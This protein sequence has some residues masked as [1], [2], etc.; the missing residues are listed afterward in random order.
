MIP[1]PAPT[2]EIQ[3]QGLD[4][5]KDVLSRCSH[6]GI[7]SFKKKY[8]LPKMVLHSGTMEI[9]FELQSSSFPFHFRRLRPP[10]ESVPLPVFPRCRL[11]DWREVSIPQLVPC[12]PRLANSPICL[13][14]LVFEVAPGEIGTVAGP[15][16]GPWPPILFFFFLGSPL[17]KTMVRS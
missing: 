15:G 4:C 3:A 10:D 13:Y 5:K 14:Y 7:F 17:G 12:R 16:I 1:L 9:C 11:A 8:T 6:F 2:G